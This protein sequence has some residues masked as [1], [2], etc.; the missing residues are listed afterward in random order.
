MCMGIKVQAR[1]HAYRVGGSFFYAKWTFVNLAHAQFA[2]LCNSGK[3]IAETRVKTMQ[4][5]GDSIAIT[6][7]AATTTVKIQ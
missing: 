3:I 7:L 2:K 5:F 4:G 6:V 1:S